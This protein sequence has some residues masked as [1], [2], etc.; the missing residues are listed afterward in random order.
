MDKVNRPGGV[1]AVGVALGLILGAG[2]G[3]VGAGLILGVALGV[4]LE[5]AGRTRATPT[6][7]HSRHEKA[8]HGHPAPRT[9]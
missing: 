1:L 2:I 8:K 4:S 5:L 3:N 7:A 9:E 6:N